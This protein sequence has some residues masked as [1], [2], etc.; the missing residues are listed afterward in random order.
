MATTRP[1]DLP[2]FGAP[3]VAEVV[4]SA[5]FEKLPSFRTVHIGLLWEHF[6]RKFPVTEE[7]APLDPIFENLDSDSLVRNTG[8]I[9]IRSFEKPP[10]P[11][12][13]FIN[14]QGSQLIQVQA[15][16]FI[17]NWRKVQQTEEYPR[18]E[19]IREAFVLE[20]ES[21]ARFVE[22]ENLGSLQFNQ[23]EITYV[24]HIIPGDAGT[25]HKD[26]HRIVR[27]W[28]PLTQGFLPPPEDISFNVR[29]VIRTRDQR[30]AGRLHT[31]LQAGW[32]SDDKAPIYILELT[33]RGAP[34]SPDVIGVTDF[35]DLGREWIVKGFTEITTDEMHALWRR[36]D[37]R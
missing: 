34:Q 31:S 10:L 22:K 5:Q 30:V 23:G 25:D 17:H 8:M 37:G 35:F 4:L 27:Y 16:R 11:R 15:D 28:N 24:N 29:Q 12:A 6:R 32:R 36:K 20:L 26:P 18:Y 1:P 19:T 9:R 21:F 3:P 7:H 33:A 2:D 14:S 13:W